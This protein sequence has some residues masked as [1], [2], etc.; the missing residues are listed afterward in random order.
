[1]S[2]TVPLPD[3]IEPR[4]LSIDEAATYLAVYPSTIKTLM[5]RGAL[6]PVDLGLRYGRPVFDRRDLDVLAD[7]RWARK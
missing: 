7:R 1:M 6:A 4:C 3:G 2:F 5:R